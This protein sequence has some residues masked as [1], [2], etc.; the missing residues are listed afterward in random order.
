MFVKVTPP[1]DRQ[2]TIY[3]EGQALE[4]EKGI[5]VAAAVLGPS[6]GW[7]RKG[8]GAAPIAIWA[9]ALNAS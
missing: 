6:H 4:V 8:T 2:V 7:T 5:S 3:F 9:C 1:A